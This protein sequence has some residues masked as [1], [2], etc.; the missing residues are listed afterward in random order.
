M[1]RHL[2]GPCLCRGFF[3]GC[4]GY[5]RRDVPARPVP[6]PVSS[7]PGPVTV[8]PTLAPR[9][10]ALLDSALRSPSGCAPGSGSRPDSGSSSGDGKGNE[11]GNGN[12]TLYNSKTRT[13]TGV[14]APS[15]KKPSSST[16]TTT[17]TSKGAPAPTKTTVCLPGAAAPGENALGVKLWAQWGATL[18]DWAVLVPWFFLGLWGVVKRN[19]LR[20]EK[21]GF[22]QSPVPA[23]LPPAPRRRA[24][25]SP[26]GTASGSG[27]GSGLAPATPGQLMAL[28]G[29][30][31][32]ISRAESCADPTGV[33]T[34]RG[35]TPMTPIRPSSASTR[36]PFRG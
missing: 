5:C 13:S 3:S 32:A 8:T 19:L 7:G 12:G 26:S 35:S 36:R 24:L 27:S 18:N 23:R 16:T 4:G 30:R 22:A 11:N 17:T 29:A 34:S 9:R 10:R 28:A 2:L 20:N 25:R 1:G 33:E 14:A 6:A 21:F 15:G 31:A